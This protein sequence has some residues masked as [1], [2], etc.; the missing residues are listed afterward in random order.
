MAK[1]SDI[2]IIIPCLNSSAL[3][4]QVLRIAL[5]LSDDVIVVDGGSADGTQALAANMGA[6]VVQSAKGRGLQL[7]TGVTASK[8]PWLLFLHSDTHLPETAE[9]VIADFISIPEN[10][11]EAGYFKLQF[12]EQSRRARALSY[13]ANWR[14]KWLG[15]P[16]GDQGLLIGRA[17]Y[18]ALDGYK[19]IPLME[20]V[21]IVR[22]LGRKR[23][24]MLEAAITTSAAKY[25]RD[26][27]MLRPLRN[28]CCLSLYFLGVAPEKIA[29]I[30]D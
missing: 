10:A 9:Q 1:S 13:L 30:Y 16:Y 20:D 24:S 3:I 29:K 21:D 14:S 11:G 15:L 26:G 27:W 4:E 5:R 2:S 17:L 23:L 6:T 7:A 12:D 22:R 8:N 18:D 25:R 28:L 19:P